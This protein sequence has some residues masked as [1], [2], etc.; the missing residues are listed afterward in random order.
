MDDELRKSYRTLEKRLSHKGRTVTPSFISV[1]N[2]EVSAT[3]SYLAFTSFQKTPGD[4]TTGDR[5]SPKVKVFLIPVIVLVSAAKVRKAVTTVVGKCIVNSANILN[6]VS[7][8]LVLLRLVLPMKV[9]TA[10]QKTPG[11]L[12]T[13]DLLSPKVKVFLIP[14]I[15]PL[16]I[17]R[18]PSKEKGK[19]IASPSVISSSSSSSDNNEAPSFLE[20]YDELSDSTDLTKAQRKKRGMFKCLNRFVGTNTKYLEKQK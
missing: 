4:L 14:V 8:L 2:K 13:R 3:S 5:L 17:S 18:N 7:M 9:S 12:T 16:D 15:D 10:S 1:R 19:K 6:A 11:D 20:F